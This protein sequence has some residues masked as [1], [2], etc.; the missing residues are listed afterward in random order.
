MR[1][2]IKVIS[3]YNSTTFVRL[4][5]VAVVGEDNIY[6]FSSKFSIDAAPLSPKDLIVFITLF[7]AQT[8]GP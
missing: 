7:N 1:L 8:Y 2:I 4:S 3:L 6:K 5:L